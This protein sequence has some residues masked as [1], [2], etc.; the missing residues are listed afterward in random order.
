[1]STSDR[2]S[3]SAG[4]SYVTAGR[5][6]CRPHR[7]GRSRAALASPSLWTRC[8]RGEQRAWEEFFATCTPDLRRL[9]G[10]FLG[11]HRRDAE[12][13]EEIVART[14]YALVRNDAK[15]LRRCARIPC[16]CQRRFLAGIVR[17]EVRRYVRGESDRARRQRQFAD[18]CTDRRRP[19]PTASD[20]GTMLEDFAQTLNGN[21]RDFFENYLLGSPDS[22]RVL[23]DANVWQRRHRLRVKAMHFLQ[24][25][26]SSEKSPK[27]YPADC[28]ESCVSCGYDSEIVNG[29]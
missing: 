5:L 10:Y 7:A 23:S 14:W 13:I 29:R 19:V 17:N 2:S 22:G 24:P 21:E 6:V 11:P 1:M 26:D 27:T 4:R 9:V 15:L 18:L 12:T 28:Q 20:Y 3:I 8:F 25:C 16:G